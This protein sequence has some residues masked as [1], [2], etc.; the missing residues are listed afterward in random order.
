MQFLIG[1]AVTNIFFP[2]QTVIKKRGRVGV[3]SVPPA[4]DI[5][6]APPSSPNTPPGVDS[7]PCGALSQLQWVSDS[8]EAGCSSEE[9]IFITSLKRKK[10]HPRRIDSSP[11]SPIRSPLRTPTHTPGRSTV[12]PCTPSGRKGM[13]RESDVACWLDREFVRRGVY[14]DKRCVQHS[15]FHGYIQNPLY[16]YKTRYLVTFF[17]HI[18]L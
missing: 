4:D 9:D 12:E 2:A 6:Q 15:F 13:K 5:P 3:Q 10:T 14:R 18:S 17:H 16:L 11:D 1:F 7:T 8:L